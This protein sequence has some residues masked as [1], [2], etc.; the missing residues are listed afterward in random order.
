MIQIHNIFVLIRNWAN[1]FIEV[2]FIERKNSASLVGAG[3]VEQH[4]QSRDASC[5]HE[6]PEIVDARTAFLDLATP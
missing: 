2:P 3:S 4:S 1:L 6:P 5:L